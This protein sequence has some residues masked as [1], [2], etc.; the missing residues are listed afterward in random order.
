MDKAVKRYLARLRRVLTCPKED[1]DRLLSRGGSLLA[2]FAAETPN[3][4]YRELTAAFGQPGDFAAEMLAQLPPETVEKARK[5]RKYIRWG[6]VAAAVIVLALL[7]IFWYLRYEKSQS[8]NENAII[9]I[10]PAKEM[11]EEETQE[12]LKQSGI[13]PR[14]SGTAFLL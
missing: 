11:T 10:E 5:R 6:A 12:Y 1:R 7:S 3:A 8:W 9:V 14:D 4:G 13:L 2:E